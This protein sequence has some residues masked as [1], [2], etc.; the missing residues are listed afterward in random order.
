MNVAISYDVVVMRDVKWVLSNGREP[1]V[2]EFT[3]FSALYRRYEKMKKQPDGATVGAE[4]DALV[5]TSFTS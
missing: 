2:D 1:A 4:Q 5:L 3:L